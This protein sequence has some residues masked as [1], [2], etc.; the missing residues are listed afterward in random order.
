MAELPSVVAVEAHV[1]RLDV[2][3][4][5]DGV[6]ERAHHGEQHR[7]RD[8]HGVV[9]GV[10]GVANGIHVLLAPLQVVRVPRGEHADP[11]EE[12]EEAVVVAEGGL[13]VVEEGLPP[14]L[15]RVGHPAGVGLPLQTIVEGELLGRLLRLAEEGA[16]GAPLRGALA[17]VDVD[18]DHVVD[19]YRADGGD[20]DFEVVRGGRDALAGVARVSHLLVEDLAEALSEADVFELLELL[21]ERVL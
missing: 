1:A 5:P 17:V 19:A 21:V 2:E 18:N 13:V 20:D 9:G 6:A 11:L 7:K 10:D 15:P 14:A 4:G 8:V 12:V 16:D 3:H